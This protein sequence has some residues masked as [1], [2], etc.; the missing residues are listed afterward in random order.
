MNRFAEL[1][2]PDQV[3][4]VHEASL[5]ILEAVGVWVRN[6]E[7]RSIFARH[8]CHVDGES[9]VVWLPREV[10]STAVLPR[11]ADRSPRYPWQATGGLDSQARALQRVRDILRR[12]NPAVFSPDVDALIRAEFKGLVAGDA[13]PQG[14]GAVE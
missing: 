3:E 1:L 7:A 11:I 4:R 10:R 13:W 14:P 8:G 9:G 5:E 12:D 2:T 6:G